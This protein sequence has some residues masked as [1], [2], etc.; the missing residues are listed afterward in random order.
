MDSVLLKMN[1]FKRRHPHDHHDDDDGGQGNTKSSRSSRDESD[2]GFDSNAPAE[3]TLR[4]DAEHSFELD[5]TCANRQKHKT[6]VQVGEK[7]PRYG[8]IVYVDNAKSLL[9]QGVIVG[10]PSFYLI[11]N[12]KL[13]FKSCDLSLRQ[14]S[15]NDEGDEEEE[16]DKNVFK[17][18]LENEMVDKSSQ[19]TKVARAY[20][21]VFAKDFGRCNW[22][23]FRK[24]TMMRVVLGGLTALRGAVDEDGA[25]EP[26]DLV[27]PEDFDSLLGKDLARY[28][29]DD[30][31]QDKHF[32]LKLVCQGE[33]VDCHKF[34]VSARS[35]VL[36]MILRN[37]SQEA[38]S[39]TVTIEDSDP[40]AVRSFVHFLYSDK[41]DS[42]YEVDLL[43]RLLHLADKY[44]VSA[45]TKACY[46]SMMHSMGLDNAAE[47]LRLGRLYKLQLEEA[48][49]A[50]IVKNREVLRTDSWKNLLRADPDGA[51][52][53]FLNLP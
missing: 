9:R 15:G 46:A 18:K 39:G 48:A 28:L 41:L 27:N 2:S 29:D 3:V 7:G 11:F 4:A 13:G 22:P 12:A 53:V 47:I 26:E 40:E 51:N 17:L 21:L 20:R 23:K 37:D 35:P 8:V 24:P 6:T 43:G 19:N 45:L 16:E 38:A 25:L 52:E 30:T 42:N 10:E 49:R 14:G 32:D 33:S 1:R 44:N 36:S 31:L 50:Y 5:L 34:I